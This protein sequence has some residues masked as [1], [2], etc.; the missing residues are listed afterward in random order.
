M[1]VEAAPRCSLNALRNKHENSG[2]QHG[3]TRLNLRQRSYKKKD[4]GLLT[5]SN[6]YVDD[7]DIDAAQNVFV[8]ST[9]AHLHFSKSTSRQSICPVS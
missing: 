2:G 6:H 5:G 1:L 7:L 4:P 8:R 9:M 3:R